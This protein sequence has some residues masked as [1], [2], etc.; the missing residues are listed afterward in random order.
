LG[1]KNVSAQKK[2][3][4]AYIDEYAEAH[5]FN[6]TVLVQ[7]KGAIAY[8]QSYG[9]ANRQFVVPNRNDT[10]YKIASITK[11]FTAVLVLQLAEKGR[12][13]LNTTIGNYLPKYKGEAAEKVTI[14]QLLHHTS[15]MKNRDENARPDKAI[16]HYQ[17]PM[18]TDELITQ[19]YSEPLVAQPGATFDYNNADYILL[20]KII[21]EQYGKPFEKV[22]S[23]KILEPLGMNMS[24]MVKQAVTLDNLADTYFFRDDLNALSNDLPVY[25]E[26]WF[27]AGGMYST[28]LDLLK[29]SNALFD[30]KLIQP[31]TLEK[32]IQPGPDDY[33]YGV[34]IDEIQAGGKTIKSVRRPG[35]I[36]GAQTML[37]HYLDADL[38]IV[39]L[40]NAGTTSPDDF[41]FAIGN[42][43][44]NQTADR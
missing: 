38:T 41:A 12:L 16:V 17:T 2:S 8:Q 1:T 37:I 43:I 20:G 9:L 24:G 23:E 33:G 25:L 11:M 3:L 13:D 26:N 28:A 32:M 27:A 35:R 5:D 21:E 14:D 7:N 34:W 36:M 19:Y 6:G 18:T 42:R 31:A 29:F 4:S 15:G 22:L 39:V 10:K 44:L 30:Y 40:S